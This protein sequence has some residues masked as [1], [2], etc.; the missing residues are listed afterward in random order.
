MT[1][2]V[3]TSYI[4]EEAQRGQSLEGQSRRRV[5]TDGIVGQDASVTT[6]ISVEPGQ[7]RLTGQYRGDRADLMAAE[8]RELGNAGSD[9]SGFAIVPY[10][11]EP[12][13]SEADGYVSLEQISVG[14]IDP[15]SRLAY[16]YDG[17]LSRAGTRRSKYR[18]L[19][20]SQQSIDHPFGNTTS[21]RVAVP[22]TA[23]EVAWTNPETGATEL[24]TAIAT[25]SAEFGDVAIYDASNASFANP[26]LVYDV[27][28]RDEPD[29]D[30]RAWDDRGHTDRE[31]ADGVRQWQRVFSSTHDHI[32]RRVLSTGLLRLTFDVA[33]STLSAETWDDGAGAWTDTALGTSDWELAAIDIGRRTDQQLAPNRADAVTKWADSTSLSTYTLNLTLRRGADAATFYRLEDS[34][35]GVP[36]GLQDLLAPIADDVI[37]DAQDAQTLR[38]RSEVNA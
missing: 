37:L 7:E 5:E 12:A 27:D 16:Q 6:P 20:T 24:P 10:Y 32:G 9:D 29:V 28:Y 1:R 14:P 2:Y 26:T 30:V 19:T 25:R 21:A 33:N 8:L 38:P 22:A 31:D 11:T 23:T 13:R 34:Q 17:A 15:S 35:S 18:A 36:S 4:P 3:Y